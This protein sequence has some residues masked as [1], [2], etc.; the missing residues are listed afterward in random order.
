MTTLPTIAITK[1]PPT[2][3]RCKG[4]SAKGQY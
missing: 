4:Q 3:A 1:R 2:F